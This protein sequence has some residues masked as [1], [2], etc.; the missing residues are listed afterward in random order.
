[1]LFDTHS[2][3]RK[4]TTIPPINLKITILISSNIYPK[5]TKKAHVQ[6]REL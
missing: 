4:I 2:F 5:T 1:M 3:P 6:V